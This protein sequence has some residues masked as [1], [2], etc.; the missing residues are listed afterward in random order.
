MNAAQVLE[1]TAQLAGCG[2]TELHH[3]DCQGSDAQAH[4]I[5][6]TLGLRIVGHPPVA[7]G[8]RA[9]CSCDELRAPQEFLT[10]NKAIVLATEVLFATPSGR[11]TLRSGTWSTIR[12]ALRMSFPVVV[13]TPQGKA[14]PSHGGTT[15]LDLPPGART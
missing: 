1:L 4:Q 14:E 15:R 6:R 9:F 7:H 13:I 10:R 12:Y 3:G 5:A 2:A 8:L 11:P